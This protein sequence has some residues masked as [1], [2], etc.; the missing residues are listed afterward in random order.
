MPVICPRVWWVS[1]GHIALALSLGLVLHS[2]LA[3]LSQIHDYDLHN[4]NVVRISLSGHTR[5][6]GSHVVQAI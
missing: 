6:L 5:I 1:L 4:S 3:D 2:R